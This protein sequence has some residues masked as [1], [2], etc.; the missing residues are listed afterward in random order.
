MSTVHMGTEQRVDG[1]INEQL[2]VG[3]H[4]SDE[5]GLRAETR[6]ASPRERT[7]IRGAELADRR[8]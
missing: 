6:L 1:V 8:F 4:G 5:R 7:L 3:S 2:I